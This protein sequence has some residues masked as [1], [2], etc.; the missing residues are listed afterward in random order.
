MSFTK[1]FGES[2]SIVVFFMGTKILKNLVF[3]NLFVYGI[4]LF[5]DA[6]A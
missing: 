1:M 4:R 6:L 3:Q 2:E 5:R